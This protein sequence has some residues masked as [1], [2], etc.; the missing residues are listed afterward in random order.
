[1]YVKGLAEGLVR[2][3]GFTDDHDS[4]REHTAIE[5]AEEKN[6]QIEVYDKRPS[7]KARLARREDAP[8][9]RL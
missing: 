1:M 5:D 2:D 8:V 6:N 7:V 3:Y 4:D 9:I